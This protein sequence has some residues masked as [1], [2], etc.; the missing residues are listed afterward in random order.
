MLTLIEAKQIADNTLTEARSRSLPPLAVA[1]LDP[2]GHLKILERED[3][4]SFLR[5]PIAI[6]KA[7]GALAMGASSRFL[8]ERLGDRPSFLGA[9]SDLAS[10]RV[11][12]VAGGLLIYRG[13]ILEGAIGVSG[14]TSDED[15][16][17]AL[18]ALQTTGLG[19]TSESPAPHQDRH[20]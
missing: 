10:G 7:W 17:V 16:A 3:D 19:T 4:A 2:G 14:A 8:G 18:A 6:G 1:I 5:P 20:P 12:P 13:Q 15:E 9:L 11:I